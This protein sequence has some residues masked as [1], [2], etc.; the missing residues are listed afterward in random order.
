MKRIAIIGAGL[1]G[2]TLANRLNNETEVQVF[3]K[4]RG[5]G[6]R[7]ATRVRNGYQFDHGAQFF[8]ARSPAFIDFIQPYM[9]QGT[10]ARWDAR[11]VELERDKITG[12]RQW[13]D[14]PAHYVAAPNMSALGQAMATRLNVQLETRI[15]RLQQVQKQ[16]Q[17]YDQHNDMLGEFDWVVLAIPARQAADLLPEQF[18]G[19]QL[20]ADKHM[21]GCYSLMLGFE[22]PL[23]LDWDAALIKQANISWACNNNSKP[24]RPAAYTLLVHATNKWAEANMEMDNDAVIE[25]L[26][27]ETRDVVGL[28]IDHAAHIDLHR[29]RYA[30]INRQT[31]PR[32]IL[33]TNLQL[34][35]IGDW[36]IKGRIESAFLSGLD[37]ADKLREIIR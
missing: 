20:I 32:A 13:R 3:E 27:E 28:D 6:G 25:H 29:W 14:D 2:L 34:G 31:G 4:S 8:T 35:A 23:P 30:N 17:L 37:A 24:G 18:E 9:E 11:F 10:I 5:H 21:L 16:W 15:D 22:E 12:R 26:L 19:R 36:C 7:M 33:D 1:A